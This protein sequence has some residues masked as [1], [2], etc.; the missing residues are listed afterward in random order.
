MPAEDVNLSIELDK[1]ASEDAS[2]DIT[3]GNIYIKDLWLEDMTGE[4]VTVDSFVPGYINDTFTLPSL[5]LYEELYSKI[6]II[7]NDILAERTI[8][9]SNSSGELIHSPGMPNMTAG[10]CDIKLNGD[11]ITSYSP[12]SFNFDAIIIDIITDSTITMEF[13]L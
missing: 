11:L 8:D 1:N 13:S 4:R 3:K 12:N 5:P 2:L 9:W 6:Y 10:S 7:L